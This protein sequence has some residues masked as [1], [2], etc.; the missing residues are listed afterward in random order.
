MNAQRCDASRSLTVEQLATLTGESV[1]ATVAQVARWYAR[2]FDARVPR[3]AHRQI[4]LRIWEY[5]I[6]ADSYEAFARTQRDPR[7]L[8]A[9][10]SDAARSLGCLCTSIQ[11]AGRPGALVPLDCPVHGLLVKAS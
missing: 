5:R 8:P 2:Q 11:L 1:R 6:D 7:A 3:V 4:G 9:C 10:A